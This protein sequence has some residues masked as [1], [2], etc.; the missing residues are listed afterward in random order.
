M[1]VIIEELPN[2]PPEPV[3]LPRRKAA[4]QHEQEF[5]EASEHLHDDDRQDQ[6]AEE[7]F[8]DCHDGLEEHQHQGAEQVLSAARQGCTCLDSPD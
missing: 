3:L 6:E 8:A 7:D 2:D 5:F 1:S 4:Q